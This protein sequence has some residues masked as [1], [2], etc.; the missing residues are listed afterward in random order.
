MSKANRASKRGRAYIIHY[1]STDYRLVSSELDKSVVRSRK[2][3]PVSGVDTVMAIPGFVFA[4]TPFKY[5]PGKYE[6]MIQ[7]GQFSRWIDVSR[8]EG[9]K[10]HSEFSAMGSEKA[11]SFITSHLDTIMRELDDAFS[12]ARLVVYPQ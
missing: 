5:P 6:L 10:P 1:F 9:V 7:K 4:E 12:V 11:V 8:E 3:I 2:S